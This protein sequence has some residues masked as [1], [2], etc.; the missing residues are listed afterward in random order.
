MTVVFV[1]HLDENLYR[2]RLP[3][4]REL[5]RRGHRVC[6]VTPEG[7]FFGRFAADGIEAVS[8]RIDRG[9]L[10][11]LR[12]RRAIGELYRALLPLEADVVHNFTAKPNIYGSFAARR[13]G[14]PRIINTVT[15]L[16]S[17]YIDD[18]LKVRTVR[19]GIEWLY[20]R[21][22]ALAHRVVFQN[23]D[24]LEYFLA[25]G[26]L[27]PEQ[28]VVIRSS[29]VDT[30]RFRPKPAPTEGEE[31]VVLMVARAIWHKGI[32]EYYR[33]AELVREHIPG[34]RFRLVGG[35]DPGNPS[36]ADEGFL[37]S[38]AV[39]W[40]GYR[41][42]VASEI[43]DAD[44]VVLPSY[45]EGVPRTLL[46]AAAM[47]RPIVT[48]DVPGCREAVEHGVNG[49][50]VPPRDSRA[51]ADAIVGL[52]KDPSLRR[53]MGA[54]GRQKALKEFSVDRVVAQYL[55]LYGSGV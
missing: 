47:E 32:R 48:T 4:M 17:Y 19:T 38:G 53:K 31:I 12:E 9:S 39:E 5:V 51:L 2:F 27:R 41:E 25:R 22:N 18:S 40:R 49:L 24:D 15:G 16:G 46:E 35:T 11:P 20:R 30:E 29:G 44:L 8:Y 14:V 28:G 45:R 34:I 26:L 54:A 37:S 52:A 7:E 13:A 50:L 33:A 1:S 3:V 6:A 43:A 23:S 42:E 36:C 10:N 55:Q 21:A